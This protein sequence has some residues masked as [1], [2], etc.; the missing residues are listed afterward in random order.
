MSVWVNV[1]R[2]ARYGFIGFVRNGFVSLAAVLIMTITLFVVAALIIGGAALSATLKQ[3]TEK[4]DVTVYFTTGANEEQIMEVKQSLEALPE[5]AVVTYMS[6][7]EALELFRERHRGD[8]LTLQALD[9][10]GENPLGASL[11]IR[12]KEPS[13][14]ESIAASLKA[15][16]ESG[17]ARSAIDKINFYQ[18][19]TAIDRLT[20][21]IEN[22]RR[23]GVAVA[24]VF[25]AATLLI[26]FNT[27]RLAIYTARDEIGVMN[28][29]GAG[30]WYVRGPFMIA[31]VLYGLVSGIV[32][33]L[34][35][36]PA[37]LW[38]GP[39]SERFFG[40]FNVFSYFI[41]SFPL[42]FLVVMGSGIGLG[43]LSS[44][45]AVR[46]YLRS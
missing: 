18:N 24:L 16:Q 33:L 41:S 12:A 6:R 38:M 15:Q 3:L 21:I 23:L 17:G 9:E 25:G 20:N 32:V 34:L 10:L 46:R 45:L 8:Q 44:Y 28:L 37:T 35:L 27:I 42:I 14:Y 2:V 5:V 7:E 43:A 30:H 31:G 40:S 1:K 29:V 36:Y 39:G 19:K 26:A 22:S 4:V 11:E 13:Q